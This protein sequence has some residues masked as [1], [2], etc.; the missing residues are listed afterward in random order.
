MNKIFKLM[1]ILSFTFICSSCF[2][3][4]NA[5]SIKYEEVTQL[6]DMQVDITFPLKSLDS[7]LALNNIKSFKG[8]KA[9][10][11]I[12]ISVEN[13]ET[14][15]LFI[16]GNKLDNSNFDKNKIYKI[17]ISDYTLNGTN[18]LQVS[19][20]SPNDA[21]INIK[22]S[23]PHVIEADAEFVGFSPD[24]LNILD[25]I[26]NKEVE[27]G[28]SGGQLV[29]IKDGCIVKNSAYGNINSYEKDGSK[30]ENP[31]SVTKDTL[32]DL[33]S[34]TK[35][36][37]T[38]YAIQ[39]LVSQNKLSIDD[40]VNKFFE[41][42]KDDDDSSIKGK[43]MI[44]IKD[45]LYHQAGFGDDPKYYSEKCEF[46]SQLK[47]ETEKMILKTPLSYEPRTK[48]LYSDLDYMLLGMI[49]EKVVNLP[50]DKFV[51]N[52]IYKP[53]GFNKIMFNPLQKGVSKNEIAATELNGNSRDGT[54]SFINNRNY[55]IQGEVHDEKAFYSMQGVSGH[56]GLFAN[57]EQLAKLAQVMLNKGGYNQ[58]KLFDSN[59]VDMFTQANNK[60]DSYALGWRKQG[61]GSYSWA[62]GEQAPNS[63]YGHT[64]WT[65]TL[66]IIDPQNDMIIIWLG[67]KKNSPVVNPNKDVNYFFGDHFLC[68][69][70][71]AIPTFI[72]EA[73]K[74]SDMESIDSLL[75]QMVINKDLI[76][77]SNKY[78][79]NQADNQALLALID[80]V[81]TRA[82]QT[83]TTENI[84]R[85]KNAIKLID[86]NGV[87]TKR[88]EKLNDK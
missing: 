31:I 71:G 42:F 37:A 60:N 88:I 58:V 7:S 51:E 19:N 34:N 84:S 1:I 87:F 61:S 73:L 70:Y 80:I 36:F 30:I 41:E 13:V 25:L 5:N 44:T 47:D 21:K 68:G 50:L 86:N 27:Y 9:Q 53:L 2:E 45:L 75:Y 66:S 69:T 3:T 48:I 29:I 72:Y 56:A 32:Y 18:T 82:E 49:V 16:N 63:T 24:K 83:K 81:I 26:I 74:A 77:K 79:Q 39:M 52:N 23:Y 33:A 43:D 15:D 67:N 57:A 22:V 59:V 78:Y 20:I 85:A 10:G 12:F 8:Y 38:N 40:K 62:F 11:E 76:M 6:G 64:G 17:D 28:F 55:T 14:F 4:K 46:F 35:M 54:V 65:G